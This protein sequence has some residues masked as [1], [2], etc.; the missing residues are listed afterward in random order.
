MDRPLLEKGVEAAERVSKSLIEDENFVDAIYTSPAIRAMHTALIHSRVFELPENRIFIRR[1]IYN[2][3]TEGMLE[4]VAGL[5]NQQQNVMVCGHNPTFTD[6][7]NRF[8]ARPIENLQ[9]SAVMKLEFDIEGWSEVRQVK[10]ECAT[11]YKRRRVI[12]LNYAE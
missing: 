1:S 4:L 3:G 7:I 9:T 10:A 2:Y 5:P 8:I 12:D 6:L 11:Y